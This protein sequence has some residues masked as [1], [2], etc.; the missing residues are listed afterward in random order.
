MNPFETPALAAGRCVVTIRREHSE[1]QWRR[2]VYARVD[3]GATHEFNAGYTVT[4][5]LKPGEH[6]LNTEDGLRRRT[7]R[8]T[9]APGEHAKF[10]LVGRPPARGLE[11]LA[12][13]KFVP[14]RLQILRTTTSARRAV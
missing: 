4:I 5:E 8:F 1:D 3:G 7:I 13:V 6:S 11:F 12:G 2:R 10:T 9:V 14:G